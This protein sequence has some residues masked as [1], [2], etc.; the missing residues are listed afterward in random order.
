MDIIIKHE[1]FKTSIRLDWT[2]TILHSRNANEFGW[3]YFWIEVIKSI[4][5]IPLRTISGVILISGQHVLMFPR[6]HYRWAA[7]MQSGKH[8]NF[9]CI[10][11]NNPKKIDNLFCLPSNRA[12]ASIF[13]QRRTIH[14]FYELKYMSIYLRAFV[15]KG[16]ISMLHIYLILN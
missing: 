11:G 9:V 7:V 15:S 5:T 3:R 4:D 10:S 8:I 14:S 13:V 2:Q 1:V 6:G 16:W 12:S